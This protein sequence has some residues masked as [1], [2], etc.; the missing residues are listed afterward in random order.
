M[1]LL[2]FRYEFNSGYSGSL[3]ECKCVVLKINPA[4]APKITL[5]NLKVAFATGWAWFERKRDA[6]YP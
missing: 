4:V 3:V 2:P 6:V 5:E 1:V